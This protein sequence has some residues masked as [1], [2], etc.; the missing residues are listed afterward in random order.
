MH[1]G[2]DLGDIAK[3]SK[4]KNSITPFKSVLIDLLHYISSG[5]NVDISFGAL[6]FEQECIKRAKKVKISD[7]NIPLPTLE[8]LIIM[9]AIAHRTKD[10]LDIETI[11]E[12]NPHLDLK[13]IRQWVKE[14]SRVLEMP[15][16]YNDLQKAV[17]KKKGLK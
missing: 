8:D 9:K 5:I 14:F 16:I 12:A 3:L 10:L 7:I 4:S 17:G 15:E 2:K 1:V 6:P 13:R 11:I